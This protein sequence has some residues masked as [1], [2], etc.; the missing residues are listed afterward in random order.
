MTIQ[1]LETSATAGCKRSEES[2]AGRD[3][4]MAAI[5]IASKAKELSEEIN[6]TE[7][8]DKDIIA[9]K[10][11]IIMWF[12]ARLAGLYGVNLSEA[13]R[14]RI[15]EAKLESPPPEKPAAGATGKNN[16]KII[17]GPKGKPAAIPFAGKPRKRAGIPRPSS[18]PHPN[19]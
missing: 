18:T 4:V 8:W 1:E 10:T 17:Y 9:K 12:C 19:P 16:A 14:K 15:E 2:R 3:E 7:R 11:A 13:V 5:E 6:L